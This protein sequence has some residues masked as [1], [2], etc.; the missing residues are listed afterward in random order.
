VRRL[1]L[2]I[3]LSTLSIVACSSPAPPPAESAAQG[4]VVRRADPVPPER[5][6]PEPQA[7]QAP[8]SSGTPQSK[9]EPLAETCESPMI[10][11]QEVFE[12]GVCQVEG[13]GA[14][15]PA[16]VGRSIDPGTI[17]ARA[18]KSAR[19]AIRLENTGSDP[20]DVFLPLPC[21]IKDQVR[22]WIESASNRPV[23]TDRTSCEQK[24]TTGC[25]ASVH[26]IRLP[27]GGIARFPFEASTTVRAWDHQCETHESKGAVPRGRYKLRVR[28]LFLDATLDADLAIR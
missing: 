6:E 21:E 22:T 19:A 28:V 15:I 13:K 8:A 5:R 20:A 17:E 26:H 23:D 7:P 4:K 11:L 12:V 3:A 9:P 2:P 27:P 25:L 14:R 18:G 1:P 16:S 10:D 24:P